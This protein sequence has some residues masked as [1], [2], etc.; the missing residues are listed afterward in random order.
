MDD[1]ELCTAEK[2]LFR[3][4]KKEEKDSKK[5]N[6]RLIKKKGRPEFQDK[7]VAMKTTNG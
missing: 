6:K 4:L 2:L 1:F 7:Q 5:E 3:T